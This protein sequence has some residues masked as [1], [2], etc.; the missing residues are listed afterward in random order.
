MNESNRV[1]KKFAIPVTDAADVSPVTGSPLEDNVGSSCG[2]SELEM[3]GA[4]VAAPSGCIATVAI[5]VAAVVVVVVVVVVDGGGGGVGDSV[6]VIMDVVS[7]FVEIV[8]SLFCPPKTLLIVFVP[9][10]C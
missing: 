10:E 8:R 2:C 9:A 6:T 5:E 1:P 3:D 4:K 7:E